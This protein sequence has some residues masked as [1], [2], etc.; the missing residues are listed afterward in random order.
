MTNTTPPTECKSWASLAHHAESWRAVQ[1]RELFASDVARA[2]QFV[3][4]APGLRLDY[5]RQRL[6][7]MTLR[8]LSHLAV[9]RGLPE[10]RD[11]LL[12][13]KKINSTEDRAAWHTALRAGGSLPPEVQCDARANE[14]AVGKNPERRKDPPRRQPRH[15]RLRPRPAPARRRLERRGARRAFRRQRRSASTCD[16][17]SKARSPRA[18]CSSSFRRPSRPRKRWPMRW[19]RRPGEENFLCSN[20]KYE[21]SAQLRRHRSTADV[22]LGR[23]PLLGLVGGRVRRGLLP[24]VFAEIRGVSR[25]RARDGQAFPAARRS[26]RTCR[27]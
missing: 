19:L 4:E 15:R 21:R 18:R 6:G 1:L 24:S 22:G 16:A 3:A 12:S 25:R 8:L 7:A 2:V 23:R 14:V 5:S 10:W 13:G 20:S 26:R 27:C 9:D 11:A 17:R